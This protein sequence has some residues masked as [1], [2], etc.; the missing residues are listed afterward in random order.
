MIKSTWLTWL[1]TR[2]VFQLRASHAHSDTLIGLLVVG[3]MY[4]THNYR[5]LIIAPNKRNL[6]SS[7]LPWQRRG[8]LEKSA[9]PH[10]TCCAPSDSDR[11][12]VFPHHELF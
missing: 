12:Q 5:D 6:N 8:R 3:D 4:D 2:R 10:E 1:I 11:L 9:P 7:D